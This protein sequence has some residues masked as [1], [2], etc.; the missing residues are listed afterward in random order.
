LIENA[1]VASLERA[2]CAV[3]IHCVVTGGKAQKDTLVSFRDLADRSESGNVVVWLNEYFGLAVADGKPIAE[4]KVFTD[5][6][7]QVRGLVRFAMHDK[8][9]FGKDMEELFERGLTFQ[10]AIEGEFGLMSR[11]R[12]KFVRREL[13]EQLYALQ[14]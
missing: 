7:H 4:M 2:G 8:P 11:Q 6:K 13:F 1:V 14:F 5:R 9:T 12:I 3:Y 10:E